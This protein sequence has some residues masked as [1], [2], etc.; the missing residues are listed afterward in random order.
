MYMCNS[1]H[2]KWRPFSAVE[3]NMYLVSIHELDEVKETLKTTGFLEISWQD[4]FL[5]W[6]PADYGGLREA[7]FPQDEVWKPDIALRNSMVEYKQL[8]VSTLNV[9][10]NNEGIV[11][12]YPF[13]VR[14]TYMY[15]R[16]YHV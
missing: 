3:V 9:N 13:Q 10:V 15:P 7:F 11:H 12:W 16:A 1:K 2:C 5:Q 6:N 4:D 14:T 8:G